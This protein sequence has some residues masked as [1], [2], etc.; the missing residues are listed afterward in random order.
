MAAAVATAI[1]GNSVEET[2]RKAGQ[3]LRYVTLDKISKEELA[4]NKP[5]PLLFERSMHGR[6]GEVD[7][8]ISHSW[9]D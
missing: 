5:N 6:F 3:L 9:S 7:A 2:E 8:F 4:E 1:G